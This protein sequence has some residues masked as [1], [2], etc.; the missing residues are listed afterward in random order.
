MA[1]LN[2]KRPF[3][4]GITARVD[5]CAKAGT[6]AAAT[7]LDNNG[8]SDGQV[9]NQ[10]LGLCEDTPTACTDHDQCGTL[11]CNEGFC[12]LVSCGLHADCPDET[13][14]LDFIIAGTCSVGCRTSDECAGTDVCN[15][16]GECLPPGQ[17][18]PPGEV[19]TIGADPRYSAG[20]VCHFIYGV[21]S[22]NTI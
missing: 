20:Y 21:C 18:L 8:C 2:L 10:N 3:S 15:N 9:C 12:S 13:F 11:I 7:C 19:C 14:C 16:Y 22:E 6:T 1:L 17:V 4:E 5:S